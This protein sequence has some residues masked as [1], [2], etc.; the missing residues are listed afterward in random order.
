MTGKAKIIAGG[1][2]WWPFAWASLWPVFAL[3]AALLTG[4]RLVMTSEIVSMLE[5]EAVPAHSFFQENLKTLAWAVLSGSG[6]CLL[7]C[8][9]LYRRLGASWRGL[10]LWFSMVIG[11]V[12]AGGDAIWALSS[13]ESFELTKIESILDW[14]RTLAFPAAGCFFL[15]MTGGRN[16]ET[17]ERISRGNSWRY[18]VTFI[19]GA[20]SALV[21]ALADHIAFWQP[22]WNGGHHYERFFK[23]GEL[24]AVNLVLFSTSLLFASLVGLL[25]V[26]FRAAFRA[27]C[28]R[29]SGR[30]GQWGSAQG[31]QALA[32]A[33]LWTVPLSWPWLLNLWPVIKSEE[34]WILPVATMGF[35]FAIL[36]GPVGMASSLLT[37][38]ELTK[39]QTSGSDDGA[40][41]RTFLTATLFPL[42]PLARWIPAKNPNR[43]RKWLLWAGTASAGLMAWM[44]HAAS[45]WFY[46]EDWR[47]ML[48]NSQLP[49]LQAYCSALLAFGV[50]V[51]WRR[52]MRWR[53]YESGGASEPNVLRKERMWGRWLTWALC[54]LTLIGGSWPFWGWNKISENT[55][56]RTAEFSGRH[57]LE[58]LT[59]HWLFDGDDDGYASVL[60][61]ADED[62]DDASLL[63]GGMLA[64]GPTFAEE[65]VF[66]VDNPHDLQN[67]PNVVLLFLEGVTPSVEPTQGKR[68]LQE[69]CA[70]TPHLD[71]L[72]ADGALFTSAR[73]LC[74][75]TWD[76][77]LAT[78]S[79]RMLR[80]IETSPWRKFGNRYS[81]L[82]NFRKIM[83]LGGVKRWCNPKIT[84]FA[85]L[86][87]GNDARRL[88]WEPTDDATPNAKNRDSET[89]RG[90][91]RL[92][93]AIKFIDDLRPL[94]K[95]TGLQRFFLCE[96]IAHTHFSRHSQTI[97]GMDEQ[98]GALMR[99]I[100][101][102][103]IYDQTCVIVVGDKGDQWHED[104]RGNIVSHLYESS[105]R[106]PVIVKLPK[107]KGL[108]SL[109]IDAPVILQDILPTLCELGGVTHKPNEVLGSLFGS[110]LLPLLDGRE[111]AEGSEKRRNRDFLLATHCDQ[112]GVL[113]RARHKLIFDRAVGT[114]R[115]F[116]LQNDPAEKVN[117]ADAENAGMMKSLAVLLRSLAWRHR[118]FLGGIRWSEGMQVSQ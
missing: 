46:F 17:D 114:Y 10:G 19:L 112:V 110:S 113:H 1:R 59:L 52:Y 76:T 73:T 50:Y 47:G 35:I 29:E 5:A 101:D 79:G 77:W 41:E 2:S 13:R 118:P 86:F 65:D 20:S 42:Y 24:A 56:A 40:S 93:R 68:Q 49:Y 26:I 78:L 18:F 115:L 111:E 15:T 28:V 80:V 106:I 74:P 102:R 57:R 39:R 70:L 25:A 66:R 37:R 58:L 91:K 98:I 11:G 55:F 81:R 103:E 117:L 21:Y 27:T 100:K 108:P 85:E 34:P 62:D 88:N 99:R 44:A 12:L 14:V 61:G 109:R 16:W 45:E 87:F 104:K 31:R 7:A 82:N 105:I 63:A 64:V 43:R 54:V 90:D 3:L 97:T 53:G 33:V 51:G 4:Y 8:G 32:V 69:G 67:F 95:G 60:H 75:S 22:A 116:D 92:N 71:E 83:E 38:D 96:H 9:A 89:I 84:G 94:E 23:Q 72:V 107:G 48:K 36:V 6:L 30:V